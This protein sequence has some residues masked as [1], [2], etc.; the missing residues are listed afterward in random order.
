M[1]NIASWNINSIRLR[2]NQLGNILAQYNFDVIALQET[3]TPDASFPLQQLHDMGYEHIYFRGEKSYNG[4]TIISKIP[5]AEKFFWNLCAKNDTRHIAVKLINGLTIHNFYVPAGGDIPDPELNDKFAH[6]LSFVTEMKQKL[7][8]S[9]NAVILGDFNIA[10]QEHDV[11]SHKA[12]SNIVSHTAIEIEKLTALQQDLG[13]I[14]THRYFTNNTEKL[15]SWW[16]YRAR[17]WAKSDR[18]RR[19]DHIWLTP[20]LKHNLQQANIYKETRAIT[21]PSDHAVISV[22]LQL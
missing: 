16:S 3:K 2:I 5:F 12:L 11:W 13:W 8:H 7:K 4:V 17:D 9:S 20:D 19:L 22:A 14:D 15:Y 1:I 6:K 10:P 18:G 21:Q